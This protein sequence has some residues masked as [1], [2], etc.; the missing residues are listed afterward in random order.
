MPIRK[1]SRRAF[2]N[3]LGPVAALGLGVRAEAAEWTAAEKANIETVDK[4]C[5]SWRTHDLAKISSH[6]TPD[7]VISYARPEAWSWS[8]RS[9]TETI[10]GT[11]RSSDSLDFKVIRTLWARGAVV[12]NERLDYNTK[13]G[14]T[15]EYPALSVYVL[16]DGKVKEMRD[17]HFAN[18]I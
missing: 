17:Y 13:D 11:L 8:P 10:A 5:A 2:V 9:A 1:L 6:F 15:V 4:L 14:K 16:K 7:G 12:V 18:P 3:G